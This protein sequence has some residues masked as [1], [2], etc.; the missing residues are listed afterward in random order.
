MA[1]NRMYLTNPTLGISVLIGKYYPSTGWYVANEETVIEKM[2]KAFHAA[3]FGNIPIE[4]AQAARIKAS[5]G[6]EGNCSW[7]IRYES[8]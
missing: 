2:N 7:C 3:D 1:N 8:K 6:S 5:G 4:A